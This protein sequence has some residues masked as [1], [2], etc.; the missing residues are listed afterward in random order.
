MTGI[1]TAELP[2][3]LAGHKEAGAEARHRIS[4]VT[5][6]LLELSHLPRCVTEFWLGV[7]EP[8]RRGRATSRFPDNVNVPCST[9]TAWIADTSVAVTFAALLADQLV[10]R[11]ILLRGYLGHS[12]AERLRYLNQH[13]I[14]PW[15]HAAVG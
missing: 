10:H 5:V 11:Q 9:A 7:E 8:T 3:V 2:E 14:E 12:R 1:E 4:D 15:R 6:P 13:A